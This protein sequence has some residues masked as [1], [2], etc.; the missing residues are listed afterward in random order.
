VIEAGMTEDDRARLGAIATATDDRARAALV[1]EYWRDGA[2]SDRT[3]RAWAYMHLGFLSGII[4]R[5]LD[6]ADT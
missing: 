5:L 4:D 1:R 2:R 3:P 6:E